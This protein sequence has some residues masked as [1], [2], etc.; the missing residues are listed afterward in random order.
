M[1]RGQRRSCR[2]YRLKVPNPQNIHLPSWL[3]AEKIEP[4]VSKQ[5]RLMRITRCEMLSGEKRQ[6]LCFCPTGRKWIPTGR[7]FIKC[8]LCPQPAQ[9]AQGLLPEGSQIPRAR[10]RGGCGHG[11]GLQCPGLSDGLVHNGTTGSDLAWHLILQASPSLQTTVVTPRWT[12]VHW[13][14]EQA[15]GKAAGASLQTVLNP[16]W[17]WGNPGWSS[18]RGY[19]GE[20]GENTGISKGGHS[21]LG[22]KEQPVQRPWRRTRFG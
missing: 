15:D 6:E 4:G 18:Y 2:Y 22:Q 20:R 7:H 5:A 21:L 14:M 13:Q 12:C 17:T 11:G 9:T 1:T 16:Q 8:S 19:S 3:A 10:D